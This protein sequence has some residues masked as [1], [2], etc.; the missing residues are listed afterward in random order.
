MTTVNALV[1]DLSSLHMALKAEVARLELRVKRLGGTAQNLFTE[2][3]KQKV[4]CCTDL[5]RVLGVLTAEPFLSK[6]AHCEIR[7]LEPLYRT[8]LK[9]F[10]VTSDCQP[11]DE[12]EPARLREEVLAILEK[13]KEGGRRS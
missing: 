2:Q 8:Y 9:L 12:S 1:R 11:S 6:Y 7:A 4:G 5:S 10:A 3:H 13:C